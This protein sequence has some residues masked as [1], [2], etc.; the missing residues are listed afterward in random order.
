MKAWVIAGADARVHSIKIMEC[1]RKRRQLGAA[2]ALHGALHRHIGL[3][4]ATRLDVGLVVDSLILLV[5]VWV[6]HQGH[7]RAW[8]GGWADGDP[9]IALRRLQCT[10]RV[11]GRRPAQAWGLDGTSKLS[12]RPAPW[13][14]LTNWGAVG[15]DVALDRPIFESRERCSVQAWDLGCARKADGG[16]DDMCYAYL[17]CAN[18]STT[19][20]PNLGCLFIFCPLTPPCTLTS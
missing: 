17:R 5:G 14:D 15:Y 7:D 11:A 16:C 2:L 8:L 19:S 20:S 1:C 10:V 13:P 18:T 9:A 12:C 6:G 3:T 4:I